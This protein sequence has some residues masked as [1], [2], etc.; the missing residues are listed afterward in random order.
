MIC[1]AGQRSPT[2]NAQ[3]FSTTAIDVPYFTLRK[4]KITIFYALRV[5]QIIF[6]IFILPERHIFVNGR[7][8]FKRKVLFTN[9]CS[10]YIAI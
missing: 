4:E 7:Y 8:F 5:H 10:L 9:R 1:W 2:S 6:F 3:D